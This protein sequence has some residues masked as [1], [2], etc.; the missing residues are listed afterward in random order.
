[1]RKGEKH[2]YLGE[3]LCKHFHIDWSRPEAVER[4]VSMRMEEPVAVLGFDPID[5]LRLVVASPLPRRK[6]LDSVPLEVVQYITF[7]NDFGGE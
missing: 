2:D 3:K 1:M 7:Q 5:L 6:R 4:F